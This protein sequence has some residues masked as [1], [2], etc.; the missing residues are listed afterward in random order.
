M[1]YRNSLNGIVLSHFY[2]SAQVLPVRLRAIRVVCSTSM[3]FVLSYHLQL[4]K[5]RAKLT[6]LN[7]CAVPF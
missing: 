1:T 5:M 4:M 7:Y 3:L 2:M 6:N